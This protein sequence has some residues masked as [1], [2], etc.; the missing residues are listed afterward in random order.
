MHTILQDLGASFIIWLIAVI[1]GA[2]VAL[3][4]EFGDD[5]FD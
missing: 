2:L 5:N 1:I 3:G 4:V